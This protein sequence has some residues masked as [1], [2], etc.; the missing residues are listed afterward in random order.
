LTKDNE[1]P[2]SVRQ[3]LKEIELIRGGKL[4]KRSA[5]EMIRRE[6][7]RLDDGR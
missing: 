6:K 5:R 7:E 1:I 4:P 2:E 3:A